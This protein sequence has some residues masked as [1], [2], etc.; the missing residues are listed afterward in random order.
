MDGKGEENIQRMRYVKVK[1][2]SCVQLFVTPWTVA[3]RAPPSMGF[4]R[5]ESG[6]GCH[7]LLQEIFPTQVSNL[8]LLHWQD[9]FLLSHLGSPKSI[10]QR[11]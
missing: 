11:S 3:H 6:V 10:A 5:Q 8:H 4:S 1:L 7:F 2:L 9:S